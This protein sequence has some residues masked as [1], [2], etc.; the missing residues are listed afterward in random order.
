M[1]SEVYGDVRPSPRQVR[2]RHDL[3]PAIRVTH[4]VSRSVE[5]PLQPTL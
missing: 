1:E 4:G 2:T 3:E 5:T